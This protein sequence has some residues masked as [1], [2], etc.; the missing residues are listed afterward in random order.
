MVML[1]D[2]DVLHRGHVREQP[3]VLVGPGHAEVRDL[4]AA[5]LVDRLA[6]E[7]DVA[8]RDVVEPG[9]AVEERRLAG[10][11]RSDDA[12]D[13]SFVDVEV[14]LV[15]GEEPAEP[16]GDGAR[17]EQRHDIPPRVIGVVSPAIMA[18]ASSPTCSSRR[19]MLDGQMPSGRYSIIP[20]SAAP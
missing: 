18:G 14:E 13:G 3:D 20:I 9:D 8:R 4:V 10:A 19:A 15:D 12:D 6:V 7:L 5:E 11:V 17:H 2:Q 1:A 16:F